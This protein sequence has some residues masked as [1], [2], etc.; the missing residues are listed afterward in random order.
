MTERK[1]H[2][3]IVEGLVYESRCLYKL[4]KIIEGNKTCENCLVRLFERMKSEKAERSVNDIKDI[5]DTNDTKV[6]KVTKATKGLSKRKRGGKARRG[7]KPQPIA[8]APPDPEPPYTVQSLSKL[9]GK[10]ERRIQELA[11]EGK[12][13]AQKVGMVW[14]FSKE[15][16][17][18]WLSGKK[19]SNDIIMTFVITARSG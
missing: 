7:R 18:H 5:K 6:T 10:S 17:D 3:E 19:E 2:C 14:Q 11:K 15:E 13:P 9:L 4:S 12:I 8:A 1:V 16:I